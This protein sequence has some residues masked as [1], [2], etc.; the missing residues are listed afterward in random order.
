MHMRPLM[1][2]QSIFLVFEATLTERLQTS[3]GATGNQVTRSVEFALGENSSSG[4]TDQP[5]T[6][7]FL[8]PSPGATG[9]Q[10]SGSLQKINGQSPSGV[11]LTLLSPVNVDRET[12]SSQ[13]VTKSSNHAGFQKDA[14]FSAFVQRSS[15]TSGVLDLSV[16]S[17]ASLQTASLPSR[18]RGVQ[19]TGESIVQIPGIVAMFTPGEPSTAGEPLPLLAKILIPVFGVLL[20][21]VV[22][23]AWCCCVRGKERENFENLIIESTLM[24]RL[25]VTENRRVSC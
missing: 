23:V 16:G 7:Y 1:L 10:A 9:F 20:V 14:N 18:A 5:A 8:R 3:S 2:I 13:K 11:V 22:G 25:D 17:S 24:V 15:P 6:S 21:V 12:A 4:A 19:T